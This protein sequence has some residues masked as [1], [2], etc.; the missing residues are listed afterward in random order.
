[1]GSTPEASGPRS[2]GERLREELGK[3]LAIS[4]YLYVCFGAI[5]LYKMAVLREA[6][7]AFAPLGLALVKALIVGKFLLIGDIVSGGVRLDTRGLVARVLVRM[8]MLLVLVFVLVLAEEVLSGMVHGRAA[9]AVLAD[10][11]SNWAE[12]A[13]TL[14]LVAVILLPLVTAI[15]IARARGLGLLETLRREVRAAGA[16][17]R[18]VGGS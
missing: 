5:A 11:R 16:D 7:V 9:A 15:E 8:A 2:L 3:Y 13:T 10:Y 12:H 18:T 1:M 17:G 4:A 6:G 14:L